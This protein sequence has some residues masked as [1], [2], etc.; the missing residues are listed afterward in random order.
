MNR[1]GLHR[2]SFASRDAA[3][4][5]SVA[6]GPGGC[7]SHAHGPPLKRV[8]HQQFHRP[9]SHN[10]Y[11]IHWV[12]GGA[13]W[14][15]HQ[16]PSGSDGP[17]VRPRRPPDCGTASLDP[18]TPTVQMFSVVLT[19]K[20]SEKSLGVTVDKSLS[21]FQEPVLAQRSW[22]EECSP[23]VRPCGGKDKLL[24]W[25]LWPDPTGLGWA[26]RWTT[27]RLLTNTQLPIN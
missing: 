2:P 11:K 7:W 22:T 25:K 6:L 14:D 3:A 13:A 17:R 4:L 16:S 23:S 18:A 27:G 26:K 15:K 9:V 19:G 20:A 1:K 12:K 8:K 5:N 21:Y 10:F 24:G